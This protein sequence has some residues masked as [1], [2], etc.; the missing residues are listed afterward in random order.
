MERCL[1]CKARLGGAELCP[2]CQADFGKIIAAEQSA[3]FWL[4][5]AMRHWQENAIESCVSALEHSFRLKKNRLAPVF[6]DFLIRRQCRVILDLLAQKQLLAAKQTLYLMRNLMP[7]S[8]LLQQL[9]SFT[10]YLWVNSQDAR[11]GSPIVNSDLSSSTS[12]ERPLF[13][14]LIHNAIIA[15]TRLDQEK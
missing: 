13:F 6:R 1:F 7:Y 11:D 9:H 15:A 2:R 3:R 14:N 12:A 10:D 5:A 8:P 4:T